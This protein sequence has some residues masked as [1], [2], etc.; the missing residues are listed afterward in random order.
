VHLTFLIC[1]QKSQINVPVDGLLRDRLELLDVGVG[2]CDVV[3]LGSFRV[4]NQHSRAG[5]GCYE[6]QQQDTT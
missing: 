5:L 3:T 4:V 2:V 1:L 6:Y